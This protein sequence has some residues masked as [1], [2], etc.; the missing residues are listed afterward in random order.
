[1]LVD[2]KLFEAEG[3]RIPV[4]IGGATTSAL[5]TALKLM[6]AYHGPVVYV[7][8]AA[9]VVDVCKQLE[10]CGWAKIR[11]EYVALA[12]A[13]EA[14][15]AR[16]KQS[17]DGIA[18]GSLDWTDFATPQGALGLQT[19]RPTLDELMPFF[20]WTPFF[21]AW[22]LRGAYPQILKSATYGDEAKK[23][24]ADAQQ[25]LAEMGVCPKAVWGFFHAHSDGDSVSIFESGETPLATFQFVRQKKP[26]NGVCHCLADFIAPRPRVDVLG[27]F[28]VTS[29]QEVYDALP[30]DD[31]KALLTKT[32]C[33]R[34]A[35]A[36]AEW[37]HAKVRR[38]FRVEG[39]IRP[40]PGYPACPDHAL[41]ATIWNVLDVSSHTNMQLTETYAMTPP[42][43][44][45]GFFFLN[46]ES[47]YF[48]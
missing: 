43:S 34:I 39:G 36:A 35:E 33:D 30:G 13:Y 45:C 47:C 14:K 25:T 40:A 7:K 8:D 46:P 10:K 37:L 41:K 4:L 26:Q 48:L 28:A 19:A 11:E 16:V 24:F 31:Y 12:E 2:L 29:G 9:S 23:L 1:M 27:L 22:G 32:L 18:H 3:L 20:D 42:S 5:H 21:V 44:I 38:D 17:F 6:P 15:T